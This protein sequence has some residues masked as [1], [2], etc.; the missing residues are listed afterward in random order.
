MPAT[1]NYGWVLPDVLGSEGAWGTIVNNAFTSADASV[2]AAKDVADAALPKAG[3]TLS[4][5]VEIKTATIQQANKGAAS[6]PVSFDVGVA[7]YH[8]WTVNGASTVTFTNLPA[9]SVVVGLILRVT[10]G[11]SAVITW[12]TSVKWPGGV[13][14]VLTVSGVDLL[15]FL[16][17]DGGLTWRGMVAGKDI[18]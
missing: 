9:G 4:G 10:N 2:K 11:E 14:P 7:Q 6:G 12:P 3:G 5:N 1:P 13:K 16:T 15:V 17:D 8:T 18:K